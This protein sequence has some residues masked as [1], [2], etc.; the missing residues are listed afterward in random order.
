M[1]RKA[2]QFLSACLL[3]CLASPFSGQSSAHETG[4]TANAVFQ[5][6]CAKC[7]GKNAEGRHFGGPSLSSQTVAGAS[8]DELNAIISNGKGRMPRYVGRLTAQE[9]ATLV[10]QIEALNR[11]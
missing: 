9:I 5:K 1:N 6:E 11:K 2:S 8:R 7:H 10:E 4:L 3:L